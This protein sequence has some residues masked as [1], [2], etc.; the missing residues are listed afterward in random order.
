MNQQSTMAATAA[1]NLVQGIATKLYGDAGAGITDLVTLAE[2]VEMSS[3]G[4]L[5]PLLDQQGVSIVADHPQPI[6][7]PALGTHEV[8]P[9]VVDV[10]LDPAEVRELCPTPDALVHGLG[11]RQ[12]HDPLVT[13]PITATQP[14]DRTRCDGACEMSPSASASAEAA[15]R[16]PPGVDL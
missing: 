2:R 8:H 5:G 13:V 10:R 15:R 12:E 7:P 16:M 11:L 9:E 4:R 1:A 14:S 6:A 3:A